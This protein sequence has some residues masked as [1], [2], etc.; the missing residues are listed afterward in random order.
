MYKYY[1]NV[2]QP[3]LFIV[4]CPI[5]KVSFNHV[6]LKISIKNFKL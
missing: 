4:N 6:A 3:I 1:I 5:Q 2:K